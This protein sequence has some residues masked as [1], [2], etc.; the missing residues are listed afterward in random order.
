MNKA[1][2]GVGMGQKKNQGEK[3]LSTA[4]VESA[5]I[6][7]S[8]HNRRHHHQP[9][10]HPPFILPMAWGTEENILQHSFTPTVMAWKNV[11]WKNQIIAEK[12]DNIN[13]ISRDFAFSISSGIGWHGCQAVNSLL[14]F[15]H[16]LWLLRGPEMKRLQVKLKMVWDL[17]RIGKS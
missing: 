9:P 2:I 17:W 6:I 8:N 16:L 10:R 12:S 3:S 15:P 11:K 5:V 14:S 4:T 7:S 1:S 13:W